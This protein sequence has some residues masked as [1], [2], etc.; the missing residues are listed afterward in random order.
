MSY[1]RDGR[2]AKAFSCEFVE[3][4]CTN[5]TVFVWCLWCTFNKLCNIIGQ[6]FSTIGRYFICGPCV[7]SMLLLQQAVTSSF[8]VSLALLVDT[9][10]HLWLCRTCDVSFPRDTLIPSYKQQHFKYISYFLH[11]ITFF[12]S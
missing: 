12:I 11:C 7:E 4:C 1:Q 5:F 6:I 10:V 2:I 8:V 3:A 9:V